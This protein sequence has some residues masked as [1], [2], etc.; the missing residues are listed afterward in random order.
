[1]ARRFKGALGGRQPPPPP[2]VRTT[3]TSFEGVP[4]PSALAATTLTK[5][6]TCRPRCRECSRQADWKLNHRLPGTEAGLQEIARRAVPSR[7]EGE[8]DGQPVH[9]GDQ[10]G[11]RRR[12]RCAEQHHTG[13]KEK[14]RDAN[15]KLGAERQQITHDRSLYRSCRGSANI[16]GINPRLDLR[17]DSS[18]IAAR[19]RSRARAAAQLPAASHRVPALAHA[20]DRLESTPALS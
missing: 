1:M 8:G 4:R 18:R 7:A 3:T 17:I 16:F 19:Y 9:G 15:D 10:I 11:R 5:Y 14:E 6:G 13:R 20:L 2:P 12:H